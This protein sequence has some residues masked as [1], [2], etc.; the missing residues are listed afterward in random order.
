[1]NMS[2]GIGQTIRIKG[3]VTA[4]EPFLIAGQSRAR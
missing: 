2:A 1:M 3:D 4:R